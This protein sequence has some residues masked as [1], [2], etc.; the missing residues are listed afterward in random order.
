[1]P[2][3]T[4]VIYHNFN[5]EAFDMSCTVT[6]QLDMDV[7]VHHCISDNNQCVL[8]FHKYTYITTSNLLEGVLWQVQLELWIM[9]LYPIH[10][11]AQLQQV[12]TDPPA[13][14]HHQLPGYV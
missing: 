1:M 14:E 10:Q 8:A 7:Y 12:S 5:N 9:L 13:Y 6:R 4:D 2:S 11:P 3:L